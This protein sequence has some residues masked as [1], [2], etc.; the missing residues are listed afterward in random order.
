MVSTTVY[1]LKHITHSS[2][3]MILFSFALGQFEK[4]MSISVG[5]GTPSCVGSKSLRSTYLLP[6]ILFASFLGI[7][8]ECGP[9]DTVWLGPSLFCLWTTDDNG[10]C[11][12]RS[13]LKLELVVI[14]L[15]VPL[16]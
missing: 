9:I 6:Q 1:A 14:M 12:D 8:R 5:C 13:G 4:S 7:G 2:I 3:D 11:K 16:I 15:A 10:V